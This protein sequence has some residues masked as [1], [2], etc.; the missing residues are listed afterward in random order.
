M[1]GT[2]SW[3]GPADGAFNQDFADGFIGKY[4]LIGI[5]HVT[6]DGE[7]IQ[8]EQLHG[9]IKQASANG[10]DI[11]LA[12]VNEGKD[13]RMPPML[14]EFDPAEPGVYELKSTGEVVDNPDFTLMVTI[15]A[16]NRS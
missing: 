7:F 11:A 8:Q 10:I 9:T 12:G 4:V 14:E 3:S 5:T 15:R 6:H 1:T 16:A 2:N 13:W